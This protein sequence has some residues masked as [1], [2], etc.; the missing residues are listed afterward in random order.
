MT[1]TVASQG[2]GDGQGND[3]GTP[4]PGADGSALNDQGFQL[5]QQGDPQGALPLLESAVAAL[6]GT[7]STTEA[8]AS[9]NLAWARFAVGRCDGVAELL[10]RSEEIQGKRKEIDRLRRQVRKDCG[11]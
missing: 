6:Q 2:G 1:Q 4:P 10:D 7:G 9:Y 8:F 3:Q 11:D 5:L